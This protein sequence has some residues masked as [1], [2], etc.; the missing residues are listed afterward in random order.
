MIQAAV[1][2]LKWETSTVSSSILFSQIH[3]IGFPKNGLT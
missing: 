3:V 1:G 2:V